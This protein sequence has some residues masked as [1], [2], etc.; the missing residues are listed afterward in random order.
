M[1]IKIFGPGC[2]ACSSLEQVTREA[3]EQLRVDAICEQVSEYDAELVPAT[4]GLMID[5]TL[6]VS[7]RVP[8]VD[9]MK[10]L[11]V[12]AGADA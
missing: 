6:L 2:H 3:M 12:E 8:Q 11:L 7:G 10:E 5:D 1:H 4:P 9:E